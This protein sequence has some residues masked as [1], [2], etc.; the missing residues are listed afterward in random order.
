MI[1]S[2]K[3][4]YVTNII[5]DKKEDV[6]T[7][8]ND[9]IVSLSNVKLEEE[10]AIAE[11]A[12]LEFKLT[13]NSKNKNR[14]N[15]KAKYKSIKETADK[16]N[17][18]NTVK[19]KL[20]KQ[21][22]LAPKAVDS[23]PQ[24]LS[25][26]KNT[27]G[28]AEPQKATFSY[29]SDDEA[30]D[31]LATLGKVNARELRQT[32]IAAESE[33]KPIEPALILKHE[34]T[35][36]EIGEALS[37]HYGLPYC[38]HDPELV[39]PEKLL[40]KLKPVFLQRMRFLP[41]GLL[42]NN[43][44]IKII[45][46]NPS[47]L[48]EE[49]TIHQIYGGHDVALYITT[50][51]EF[52]LTYRDFFGD[53]GSSQLDDMLASLSDQYGTAESDEFD[54]E[55]IEGGVSDNELVLLVNKIITDAYNRNVSDIHIEPYPGKAKTRIRF[56]VDG[57]MMEYLTLPPSLKDAII[58]RI[59]VMAN[60]DISDRRR[61]QDGKIAMKKFSQLKIE[62]RVA[63]IP[64][65]GNLED[66]V[67]RIL[68]S[69]E[70]LPLEKLG[71]LPQNESKLIPLI[72][73]PY[74]ILFVCGPTGSGKTTTLH[75]ILKHLN[76]ESTK[77]WTAED[78][79]EITQIG[80]RQVQVNRKA[81]LDFAT[82][83]RAFLR[84][85]PD[86]IMVGEMRDHETVSTGVEASLT[87]HLVMST[88][89]TNSAPEAIVRLLDMGIDPF[90]FADALLGILAQRLAKRLCDC[91]EDYIADE[92]EIRLLAQEYSLEL[93]KT[94]AWVKDAKGQME[95]LLNDWRERYCKDKKYTLSRAKGCSSCNNGYKGRVGL[96]ELMVGS[97]NVK[98]LIQQKSTVET[99]VA[100]CLE[101]GML[102]LK[103][104]GIL[105]VLMGTT[106]IKQV[107]SVCIK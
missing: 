2:N 63:T 87:G 10:V 57:S 90:N 74:G 72:E 76:T 64:T 34:F 17:K 85:D 80:L 104:D 99:L 9:D 43:Q 56:R 105:K 69:G 51:I 77:I 73:K 29:V 79:V 101:E 31:H 4:R 65:S 78:P 83:M 28:D 62:L 89:H 44:T 82:T 86:I 11:N 22:A 33:D 61:P 35:L 68:A 70:P 12:D 42:E 6:T 18:K 1:A 103:M 41:I 54:P 32:I 106:D 50:N 40:K 94:S 19:K 95:S 98:R 26:E 3:K 20:E 67:L 60:L 27:A 96:H 58:T 107:R 88:L 15:K 47:Q 102:T 21:I 13:D 23:E 55:K 71:I 46:T 30:Y 93:Q 16:E 38:G 59:K 52:E 84:A 91:K 66:A 7:L 100:A 75:S 25:G 37:H 48:E 8:R 5:R 92:D 53:D 14:D 49:G 36:I 39:K 24:T 45:C 97:D 81:G